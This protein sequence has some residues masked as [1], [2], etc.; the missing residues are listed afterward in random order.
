M[1]N[2][3]LC[4]NALRILSMDEI[5]N[6]KSGHPGIALGAAPILYSLYAKILN[7]TPKDEKHLLRDRFVLSAGHGSALLYAT[8]HSMGFSFSKD[9]LKSF[10]SINSRCP[11][12]P[13]CE[14]DNAIDASTGP[15]GQGLAN[16][17][18]MAI[19]EKH[20]ASIF[21]KPD[22]KLFDNYTYCLVGDG[23][24]MEG[25]SHEALSLAGTL[26]L[27]KLIVIYDSNNVSLD[28]KTSVAFK[29]NTKMVFQGY[30]FNV[31]EVKDGNNVDKI[32]KAIKRAKLSLN[33]PTLVVVNTVIGH[34][35]SLAG[36]NKVHG[37]PLGE[38]E[39]LK[40]RAKLGV[41]G[42]PFEINAKAADHFETIKSRFDDVKKH[43]DER[44]QT[45]KKHYPSDYRI[46]N[47]YLK[48]D[49]SDI[50]SH[51]SKLENKNTS[52]RVASGEILNIIAD[53][54][55]NLIGGC[56]DVM[57]STKAQVYS[58]NFHEN[59]VGR[60]IMFGVREFGMGAIA[61]GISLYGC[62]TPF[63]STF[64]VFADYLKPALRMSA[65]T[66][67]RVLYVLT[68]DSL[69]V[70]KDGPTHQPIEQMAMFRS[71]PNTYTFRPADYTETCA[72]YSSALNLNAPSVLVLTRQ[73]L[74]PLNS[75][76]EG[77]KQGGYIIKEESKKLGTVLIA[78]GSEVKTAL[79]VAK[80]LEESAGVGVRVV[81]MPCMELFDAQPESYK[82]KVLNSEVPTFSIELSSD[83]SFA[84][85]IKTGEVIGTFSFGKSGV[86]TDVLKELKLDVKSIVNKI[87][88]QIKTKE[89]K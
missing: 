25:I 4:V 21:N 14:A 26:K 1:K 24:L 67:R 73:D 68:H 85:Y 69:M 89:T 75:N 35:S 33:K 45:Y 56:A 80:E 12:H 51:V 63:V 52:S 72:A 53:N 42:E 7:V 2:D 65:L 64:M 50:D 29:Q 17:V 48:N 38:D 31:I 19:A 11:G 5:N 61:N 40:L 49:F 27:N 60:N 57:S 88:K 36:S 41:V 58:A 46:L 70:G 77:A 8:L 39:T 9:D 3:N 37:A 76:F 13:E 28:D 66:S 78:T 79:E 81:S 55:S 86:P 16:A 83:L 54:Y 30:G 71:Q 22:Y 23:C 82:E 62:L 10:R 34:G 43:F 32:T 87:K 15:L 84:K 47:M 20:L 59:P 6:A 18:G 44:M 74:E